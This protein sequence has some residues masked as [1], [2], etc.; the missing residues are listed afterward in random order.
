MVFV[1]MW[2]YIF[3]LLF[4]I[5]IM[6]D[7]NI[8]VVS[9]LLICCLWSEVIDWKFCRWW[10]FFK[11][12]ELKIWFLLLRVF[13]S[14]ILE[15]V[16]MFDIKDNFLIFLILLVFIIK[17]FVYMFVWIFYMFVVGWMILL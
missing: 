6:Y 14:F 11:I 13:S 16:G 7:F 15:V 2:V 4:G 10:F 12:L 1:N 9:F 5:L 3:E 17:L 8:V